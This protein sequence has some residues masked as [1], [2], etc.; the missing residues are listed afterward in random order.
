M[1]DGIIAGIILLIVGLMFFFGNKNI[2]E[3]AYKFYQW[4]YTKDRLKIMFKIV[5]IILIV[6]GFILL[7]VK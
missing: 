3:G 7:V 6:G 2:G 4:F 1:K 5:G